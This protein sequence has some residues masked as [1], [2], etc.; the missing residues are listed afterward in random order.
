MRDRPFVLVVCVGLLLSRALVFAHHAFD[1]EFDEKDR[2]TLKGT[3]TKMEWVNPHGWIYMSVKGP[4][5]KLANW[6]I[7]TGPPAALLRR[8]LKKDDFRVGMQLTVDIAPEQ[9]QSWLISPNDA[10]AG[11]APRDWIIEGRARDLL[12]EFRRMQ[13]GEPV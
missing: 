7:E 12:W 4:D 5:G 8:G 3:L 11:D 6:A 10:F 9:R 13:V 2:I 1:T